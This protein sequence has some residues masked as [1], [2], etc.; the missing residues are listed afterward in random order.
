V[1]KKQNTTEYCSATKTK[2]KNSGLGDVRSFDEV[3]IASPTPLSLFKKAL[4]AIA[5]IALFENH[6]FIHYKSGV[7]RGNPEFCYCKK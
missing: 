3:V 5:T 7:G 4:F 2:P 6:I 1:A